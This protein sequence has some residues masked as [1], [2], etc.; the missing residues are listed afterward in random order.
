LVKHYSIDPANIVV[1]P[2]GIDPRQFHPIEGM[3]KIPGSLL[4]VGRL[5]KRK[6]VDFLLRSMCY[7]VDEIPDAM[8]YIGGRGKGR[9]EL[10]R[11]VNKHRLSENVTF[12]GHIP[13]NQINQ[14]YN[15]VGC[16]VVP[17][18]FEGFGLTV[19]EAMAAGTPVIAT[20]VDS[21]KHLITDGMDGFL[22][23]YGDVQML[24]RRISSLLGDPG[25]RA[26]FSSKG[27]EKTERRYAWEGIISTYM[28]ETHLL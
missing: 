17:S 10:Q 5:D 21:L 14:W 27:L 1:N 28:R 6:G 20:Q 16:V 15:R 3:K 9:G 18:M 24:G 25:R 26:A 8:L 2:I 22:V 19:T 12:L 11:Y 23:P 7:V 13:G 4:F